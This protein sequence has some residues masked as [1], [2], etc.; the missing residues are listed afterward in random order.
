MPMR[1]RDNASSWSRSSRILRSASVARALMLIRYSGRDRNA[2]RMRRSA[3]SAKVPPNRL[4]AAAPWAAA[5]GPSPDMAPLMA[6][7][8]R[9]AIAA[10]IA[11]PSVSPAA[12]APGA[13]WA[14]KLAQNPAARGSTST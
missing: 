4:P 11:A 2:A 1:C 7:L 8:I 10:P 12:V 9:A 3:V 13:V 14:M 6:D 5:V